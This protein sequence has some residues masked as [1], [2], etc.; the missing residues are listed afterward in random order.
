L[1]KGFVVFFYDAREAGC[2]APCN[3]FGKNHK[4]TWTKDLNTIEL[5]KEQE[6]QRSCME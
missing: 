5:G 3:A 1:E 2:C 6:Q 4:G